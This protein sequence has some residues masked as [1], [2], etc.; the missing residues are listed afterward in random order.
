MRVYLF[1]G[2]LL[3]AACGDGKTGPASRGE[4]IPNPGG[5]DFPAAPL[6]GPGGV[7]G[8]TAPETVTS[9][10]VLAAPVL[11][12]GFTAVTQRARLT[13]GGVDLVLTPVRLA[14]TAAAD[15]VATAVTAGAYTLT[16]LDETGA[17]SAFTTSVTVRAD[18]VTRVA[19]GSVLVAPESAVQTGRLG[20]ESLV[21][22][23]AQGG[24][25]L[26]TVAAPLNAAV[27]LPPGAFQWH[28]QGAAGELPPITLDA[29][30]G[31]LR[32]EWGSVYVRKNALD[33]V[34]IATADGTTLIPAAADGV[35]Y[36]LPATTQSQGCMVYLGIV[37]QL[38]TNT[39]TLCQDA[40][41]H[42][43]LNAR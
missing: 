4:Q 39:I 43:E 36:L 5:L 32:H 20:V 37:N 35:E 6:E 19:L 40:V 9:A 27:D 30:T 11:P 42:F 26:K 10:I 22:R 34:V 29:G 12:A 33:A 3:A 28:A 31:L 2:I 13:G 1:V 38:T 23:I 25:T 18:R 14:A 7:T 8:D 15:A 21:Y 24:Q 17:P 41:L 16:W